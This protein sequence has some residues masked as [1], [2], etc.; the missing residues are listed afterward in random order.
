VHQNEQYDEQEILLFFFYILPPPSD[1]SSNLQHPPLPPPP[2]CH[3]DNQRNCTSMSAIMSLQVGHFSN[4]FETVSL[5]SSTLPDHLLL[6]FGI[7]SKQSLTQPSSSL[8]KSITNSL[9]VMLPPTPQQLKAVA[10]ANKEQSRSPHARPYGGDYTLLGE[11]DKGYDHVPVTNYQVPRQWVNSD[12]LIA[13]GCGFKRMADYL[14][15]TTLT[16]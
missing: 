5:T 2:A 9:V 8:L 11:P 7:D 15:L 10:G 12:Q 13:R 4:R 1:I 6:A 14:E 16:T 3:A